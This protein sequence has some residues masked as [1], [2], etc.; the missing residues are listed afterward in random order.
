MILVVCGHIN[1]SEGEASAHMDHR[2]IIVFFG[3]DIGE[4]VLSRVG[5]IR[6]LGQSH[7]I[8]REA[9]AKE[10]LCLIL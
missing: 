10:G 3:E 2:E 5:I 7:S 8:G 9:L 1:E 6:K 4:L